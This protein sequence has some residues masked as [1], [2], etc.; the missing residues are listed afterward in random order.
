MRLRGLSIAVVVL[1]ALGGAVYWSNKA[2]KAEEGKPAAGAPPQVLTI[3]S[4]EIQQVEIR[5]A[6]AEP[7]V[8]RRQDAGPWSMTSP[9]QW[10][11]DQDAA[12]AIVSTVSSLASE[13]LVE[14]KA[15]DMT[16][17]GL[18][19][20][21]LEI[22]IGLKN[23][24]FRKLLL[25]DETPTGG[26]SFAKVDG[27]SKV[28]V[29]GSFAKS[30]LGK[31]PRDLRDKRLLTFSPEKLTRVELSAKGQTV[32]FGKDGQGE[33][34]IIKPRPL[35]ADGGQVEDLLRK[36]GEARMDASLTEDDEKKSTAAFNGAAQVAT[37]RATDATG[38]QQLEVRRDKD[39]ITYAR[40]S[41]VAGAHK[42]SSD[43]GDALDKS[44][45]DF[46][47][48]KLFDFGFSDATKVELRDGQKQS[49][50]QKSGEKWM[51]GAKQMDP[52][53]VNALVDRLR[54]LA[55]I[56]FVDSGFTTPVF[57]AAVTSNDGKRVERVLISRQG[58]R[59]FA[60]RA[61]E[62]SVYE[63]DAKAVED[64]QKALAGVKEFQPPNP[65]KKK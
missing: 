52:A 25:G 18:A 51:A 13:R 2:K 10:P 26:G 45:T 42:V 29:L 57:E 55:A 4:A 58:A 35:R 6:G 22:N 50:F 59:C 9:P 65:A 44:P 23:G 33:W 3:P 63:L 61:G 37:V 15:S 53:S 40:S 32:E 47:D 8:I 41:A 36:L 24:K 43:L 21:S 34:Q 64:I 30:S 48:K 5:R 31:T 17:F 46:R 1:L 27:E 12:G 7:V 16:P 60:Q 56:K 49:A 28:Y 38:T 39:K 19:S 14:E 11:V 54:E 62:P 20:P